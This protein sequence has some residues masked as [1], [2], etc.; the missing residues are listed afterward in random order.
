MRD[1]GLA[2]PKP[3]HKLSPNKAEA[4]NDSIPPL[5]PPLAAK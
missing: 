4:P 2:R 5:L 1:G 3:H